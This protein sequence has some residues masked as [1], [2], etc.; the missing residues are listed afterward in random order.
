MSGKLN[1][2]LVHGAW[3]DGS[4]WKN[5]IPELTAAGYTVV[6]AQNP[7][8]ALADDVAT[9]KRL[10]DSLE[11]QTLL[12][13]HSYGGVVITDTAAK[14]PDVVGL[15]YIAAFAPD[16]TENLKTLLTKDAIPAG[17]AHIYPDA[18][19]YFWIKR[20][21]FK[22]SF[23]HDCTDAEAL[24]MAATHKP[25]FGQCFEDKPTSVGWKK[26]PVWYQISESDQMLPPITQHF[27]AERM[28]A[29]TLS[30]DASH[31]SMVSHPHEI[32]KL[33]LRAAKELEK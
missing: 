27:F 9:V 8:T 16:E 22:E 11:G 15:V 33:I 32:A 23:A 3:G 30:L 18:N 28:N 1:I 2:V 13:G 20:D 21:K 19:G 17:G 10:I 4:H 25:T 26:L 31:A 6:A 29:K 24:V 12:V 7:L 5:V 14:C